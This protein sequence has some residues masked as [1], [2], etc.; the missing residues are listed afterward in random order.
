MNDRLLRF[1]IFLSALA[2][3]AFYW[4]ESSTGRYQ[5]LQRQGE[6]ANVIYVLDTRTGDIIRY[7]EEG[8]KLVMF[9]RARQR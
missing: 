9:D 6:L 3:L 8:N 7:V 1:I 4:V 5:F 2:A